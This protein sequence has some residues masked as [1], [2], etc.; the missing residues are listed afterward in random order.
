MEKIKEMVS[1]LFACGIG[2]DL[3]KLMSCDTVNALYFREESGNLTGVV[4]LVI[5]E[6]SED[7]DWTTVRDIKEQ[8]VRLVPNGFEEHDR[9]E[10]LLLG[11]ALAVEHVLDTYEH[12]EMLMPCDLEVPK[13]LFQLKRAITAEDYKNAMLVKSRLGRFLPN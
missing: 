1:A 13:A 12:V 3:A 7:Q 4:Q 8:R 6:H 9:L 10:E 11:W 5:Y 2:T